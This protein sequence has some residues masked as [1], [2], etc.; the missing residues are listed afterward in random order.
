MNESE[1]FLKLQELL[2]LAEELSS[3]GRYSSEEIRDEIIE[4]IGE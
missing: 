3:S 4:R 1:A 2:A